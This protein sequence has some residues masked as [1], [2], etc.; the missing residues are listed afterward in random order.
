MTP[1][2]AAVALLDQAF[3]EYNQLLNEAIDRMRT[4]IARGGNPELTIAQVAFAMADISDTCPPAR[5]MI[6]AE[7]AVALY[8][9]SQQ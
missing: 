1:T 4:A 6:L 2:P 5:D 8:R 9:L 7:Y 3:A